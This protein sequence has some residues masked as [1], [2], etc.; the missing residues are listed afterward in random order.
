MRGLFTRTSEVIMANG[1][2]L[3][4]D[5]ISITGACYSATIKIF[6][7]AGV[8]VVDGEK[9]W[10]ID[11]SSGSYMDHNRPGYMFD[12]ADLVCVEYCDDLYFASAAGM[13]VWREFIGLT[14]VF[15]LCGYY[16]NYRGESCEECTNSNGKYYFTR[17]HITLERTDT[18]PWEIRGGVVELELL[19]SAA[20]CVAKNE[21]DNSKRNGNSRKG[22]FRANR[23]R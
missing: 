16:N 22:R 21:M 17:D 20:F 7:S 6:H 3:S 10:N 15:G 2:L 12:P 14:R 1:I 5:K 13:P 4:H 9:Y 23:R 19:H 11:F 18:P 8:I